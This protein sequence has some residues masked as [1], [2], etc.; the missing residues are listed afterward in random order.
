LHRHGRWWP[1]R[2]VD[3]A[4]SGRLDPSSGAAME[5]VGGSFAI[6]STGE[7]LKILG[8]ALGM[9]SLGIAAF[10]R[11]RVAL[12]GAVASEAQLRGMAN[13]IGTRNP[14]FAR[15]V[16]WVAFVP[17]IVLGIGAIGLGIGTGYYAI[18]GLMTSEQAQVERVVRDGLKGKTSEE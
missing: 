10:A 8:G 13:S 11:A 18:R 16:C 4:E 1:A 5:G 6:V 12:R 7:A 14:R 3:G 15:V 17:C 2:P 9:V